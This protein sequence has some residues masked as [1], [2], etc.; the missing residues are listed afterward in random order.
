MERRRAAQWEPHLIFPDRARLAI[1]P[2]QTGIMAGSAR[3][4]AR[5]RQDRV[6]E[7]C[8][9]EPFFRPAIGIFFRIWNRGRTP[10]LPLERVQAD[11]G[12]AKEG[13]ISEQQ[14]NAGRGHYH[15]SP[16]ACASLLFRMA[17]DLSDPVDEPLKRYEAVATARLWRVH[18]VRGRAGRTAVCRPGLRRCSLKFCCRRSSS[19]NR[20][21]PHGESAPA[22][23]CALRKH[24]RPDAPPGRRGKSIPGSCLWNSRARR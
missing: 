14:E 6:K 4:Y 3:A 7:Q 2:G 16:H 13:C 8:P 15:G 11:F 22:P 18:H 21:L 17:D 5:A 24:R 1:A 20:G 12:G 23:C 9:A 10:I 19:R